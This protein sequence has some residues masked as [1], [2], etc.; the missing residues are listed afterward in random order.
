M[1]FPT[2]ADTEQWMLL[3][4]MGVVRNARVDS[5]IDLQE[6]LLNNPSSTE[7]GKCSQKR[8]NDAATLHAT[9]LLTQASS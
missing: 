8:G 5:P 6:G 7:K 2:C 4:K 1:Q 3:H 9:A